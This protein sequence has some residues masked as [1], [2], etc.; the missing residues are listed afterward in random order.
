VAISGDSGGR[1]APE[2]RIVSVD[3]DPV[4]LAHA[5]ELARSAPGGSAE[6][7]HGD[8]TDPATVLA[9]A[10][11]TLDLGE[12][13][14]IVLAAVLHHVP[15]E[16]DP[17]G[18][19]AAFLDAVPS[20][21]YLVLSHLTTDIQGEQMDRLRGSVDRQAAYAFTMRSHAEVSRLFAGLDILDP[22]IVSVDE[23]RRDAAAP[24][25]P[26][27]RVTPILGGVGRKP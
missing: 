9:R 14:A 12:P 22:G 7:V 4:V 23:W 17:Y 8:M 26:D 20:G 11:A 25:P 27:G 13:V 3:N 21:S 5:H 16:G 24:T 15:D 19:V 10:G 2:S 1:I 18:I 6:Y